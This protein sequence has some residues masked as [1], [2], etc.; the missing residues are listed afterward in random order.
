[1]IYLYFSEPRIDPQAAGVTL[2]QY[3]TDLALRNENPEIV[4]SDEVTRTINGGSPWF[5][6]LELAD[7][8]KVDIEKALTLLRRSLNPADYI[9]VFV[10]NL[11]IDALRRHVE[12]YLASIPR[13]ETWNSWR[14]LNIQRPGRA[15]KPVYKGKEEQSAVY[16]AWYDKAPYSE[17]A[18]AA[19]SVLTEYL[20]IRMTEDIREK[21]GGVYSIS[22]S[23]A[24]SPVPEGE[25]SL[26]VYFACDPHRAG[27]L[28]AAVQELI[29]QTSS[30]IIHGDTFTKS[31]EA[32]KKDW[33]SSIQGNAYIARSYANSSVLLNLPLSRLDRRPAYYNGVKP[34]DIQNLCAR[35]IPK[36]PATI[37]L[38]P[39]ANK[40]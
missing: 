24:I 26:A 10:G 6:P 38:Y 7:L 18:S 36:G 17:E 34:A 21:L 28:T 15:D 8:D 35:L 30:G 19:A 33:E 37:V 31:V 1:M 12:T 9:F 22:A 11:D 14:N 2:D 5:E 29:R 13:G 27:E 23:A 3:R 40:E 16:M 39:E 20:D 25:L 32:L 4:F